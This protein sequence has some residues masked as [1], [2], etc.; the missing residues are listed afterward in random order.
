MPRGLRLRRR[1]ERQEHPGRGVLVTR[2]HDFG[3]RAGSEDHPPELVAGDVHEAYQHPRSMRPGEPLDL[4][5]QTFGAVVRRQEDARYPR[6]PDH[7]RRGGETARLSRQGR[8]YRLEPSDEGAP[9]HRVSEHGPELGGQRKHRRFHTPPGPELPRLGGERRENAGMTRV[10][11]DLARE[12]NY[13]SG[14]ISCVPH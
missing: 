11:L 5:I 2:E 10:A 3:G 14:A 8:F 6:L 1:S 12:T 7:R 4:A 13:L 9:K